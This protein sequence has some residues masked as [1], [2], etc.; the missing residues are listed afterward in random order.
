MRHVRTL[1]LF[2]ATSLSLLGCS[3][4]DSA[5]GP[6]D[7]EEPA[8]DKPSGPDDPGDVMVV[9]GSY[10]ILTDIDLGSDAFASDD[11]V[12][13][14]QGIKDAPITT[15]VLSGA[16]D[17]GIPDSVLSSIE[18]VLSGALPDGFANSLDK[19]ADNIDEALGSFQLTSELDVA[20]GDG[21]YAADHTVTGITV[22][23][24]G[25]DTFVDV[26]EQTTSSSAVVDFTGGGISVSEHEL[27][28]PV[29]AAMSAIL[30]GEIARSI[31]PSATTL[32]EALSIAADCPN[33]SD[34]DVFGVSPRSVCV[35][36]TATLASNLQAA[37]SKLDTFDIDMTLTGQA[38]ISDGDADGTFDGLNGAWVNGGD[39]LPFVGSRM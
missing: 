17:L 4:D 23:F 26:T 5:P 36:G 18:N 22:S 29:G 19:L 15:L 9:A 8:P 39:S 11:L 6:D 10:Q 14:L 27:P 30:D 32:G 28:V 13:L 16:E 20:S 34:F 35:S 24:A 7:V 3:F 21:R 31:A 37:L 1:A 12:S 2:L 33:M 38:A 25:I